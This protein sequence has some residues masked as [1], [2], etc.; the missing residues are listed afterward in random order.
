MTNPTAATGKCPFNH[1]AMTMAAG[2]RGNRDWWPEQLNL[3][4]LSQQ[5]GKTS[6]MGPDFDYAKAFA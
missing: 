3:D 1:S 5:S 4:I 6:P 2:G